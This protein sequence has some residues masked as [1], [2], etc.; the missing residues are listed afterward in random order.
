MMRQQFKITFEDKKNSVRLLKN[1]KES[2]S[3]QT[4]AI[5]PWGLLKLSLEKIDGVWIY[6]N[7]SW[8]FIKYQSYM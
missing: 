4:I 1:K 3:F 6:D 8:L 5:S 2:F 7:F